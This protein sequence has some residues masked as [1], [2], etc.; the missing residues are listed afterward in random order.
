MQ[1]SFHIFRQVEDLE[2]RLYSLPSYLESLA[3]IV[4]EVSEVL[5]LFFNY[6]DGPPYK[7]VYKLVFWKMKGS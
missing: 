4:K 1:C 6:Q 3:N 5:N 7:Q 2:D